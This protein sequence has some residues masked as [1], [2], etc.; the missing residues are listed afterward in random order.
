MTLG[1]IALL[2][3]CVLAIPPLR[4]AFQNAISGDHD[5]VR[6]DLQK[7]AGVALVIGL[8]I[9]HTIV[10]YPAE[11]LDTAAGYVYGFWPALPLIMACWVASGLLAYMIGRHAARPLLYRLVGEER[12]ERLEA[13]VERGGV[14]FLLVARLVPIVPFSLTGYVAGAARV[15]LGRFTWTTAVGYLPIT[16]FFIYVGSRLEELSPTDPV[17][18]LGT[19]ALLLSVLGVR[20][21][22][23]RFTHER[24]DRADARRG[25]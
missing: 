24:A 18:L 2:A 1:G 17:I 5:A 4:D 15:P 6:E 10:W 7:P 12:F 22:T 8:A 9:I 25:S 20:F 13:L 16:A 3:A 21:L 11:I 23:P 19:G 14:T